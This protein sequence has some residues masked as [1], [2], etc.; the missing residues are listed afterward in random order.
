M[1]AVAGRIAGIVH[2]AEPL[3]ADLG[4][5]GSVPTLVLQ[6]F[7]RNSF[8][9]VLTGVFYS[10]HFIAPTVFAFILWKYYHDSYW[11]YTISIAVCTYAALL[12]FLVYPVAPP[13][14]GIDAVR[15]L[16]QLDHSIGVPVYKTIFDL[17]QPNPFAAFPSL[18]SAY[19]WMIALFSFKVFKKKAIP[20]LIFPF[21]VWFSTIYLGE[22]YVIDVIGGV[23]YATVAFLLVERLLPRLIQKH[24][25]LAL[26]SGGVSSS[27]RWF[28]EAADVS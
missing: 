16:F 8:L 24:K 13:W 7:F 19:P 21:G 10:L 17:I 14:Y 18:H 28:Y 23:A 3:Y 1:Y 11:K 4:M 20:V 26:G 6:Q 2:V 9:D 15:V 12:T 27:V 25:S 5:F 22:H